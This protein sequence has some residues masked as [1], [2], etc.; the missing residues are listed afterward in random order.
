M[1]TCMAGMYLFFPCIYIYIYIYIHLHTHTHTNVTRKT[2]GMYVGFCGFQTDSLL[3]CIHAYV[4]TCI[5]THQHTNTQ[6]CDRL[7]VCMRVVF[8][9]A[10][11]Q[12]YHVFSV[13]V[14]ISYTYV[15]AY[16]YMHTC[17]HTYIYITRILP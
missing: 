1:H 12:Q 15:H 3:S 11:L 8:A 2:V 10:L 9:S 6:I 5:R 14:Y 13:Y 17:M 7:Y 16:T 4:H